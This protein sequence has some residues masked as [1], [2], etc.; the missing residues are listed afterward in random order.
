M[1]LLSSHIQLQFL[2][3]N[4]SDLTNLIQKKTKK[5]LCVPVIITF[6]V[7]VSII[8]MIILEKTGLLNSKINSELRINKE[9]ASIKLI[10]TMNKDVNLV[11]KNI[12]VVK[13]IVFKK[14]VKEYENILL[15]SVMESQFDEDF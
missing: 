2:I 3:K 11:K 7:I 5:V 14:N 8:L 10:N 13:S 1:S 6:I 15:N 12:N 4:V 9:F